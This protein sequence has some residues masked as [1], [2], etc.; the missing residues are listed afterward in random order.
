M[1]SAA[2]S[3]AA[4]HQVEINNAKQ[5]SNTYKQQA[6][7]LMKSLS[8]SGIDKCT[9]ADQLINGEIGK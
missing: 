9:A 7:N 8:Q 2:E 3:Q 6:Q 4:V 1:K 5:Q